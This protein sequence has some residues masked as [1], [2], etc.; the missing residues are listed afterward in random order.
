MKAVLFAVALAGAL[1]LRPGAVAAQCSKDI[2]CKGDRLCRDG[3]CV[4]PDP[5]AQPAPQPAPV[6]VYPQPAPVP[7]SASA[8]TPVAA[9]APSPVPASTATEPAQGASPSRLQWFEHAYGFAAFASQFHGWGGGHLDDESGEYPREEFTTDS[10]FGAGVSLGVYLVPSESFHVGAFWSYYSADLDAKSKETSEYLLRIDMP[11]NDLGL[12]AKAGGRVAER[13][14]VGGA[15]DLAL[16]IAKG[17]VKGDNAETEPMFGV[18]MFPRFVLDVMLVNSGR[19]RMAA[20][21]GLGVRV[22][23]VYGG[24]PLDNASCGNLGNVKLTGWMIGPAL[25][26][27]LSLGG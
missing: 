10:G 21:L 5:A 23:P 2:E 13:V 26:L 19:F 17:K 25:L 16:A 18:S 9:P 8:S 22:S 12:A 1:A 27:G 6:V 4:D 3:R 7:A 20:N 14:W 15:L 11:I 24:H